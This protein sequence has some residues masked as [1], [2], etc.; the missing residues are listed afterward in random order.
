[1]TTDDV[2]TLYAYNQWANHR[3]LEAS[4]PLDSAA[5]ARNLGNSFGSLRNT[6]VHILWAEW[7]WLERWQRRSPKQVFSPETFPD[8]D[9]IERRWREIER[10]QESFVAE[11]TDEKLKERIAYENI[12]GE[13]WD[14]SLG[15]MMQHVVNHS[16]YHRGQVITSLRQLGGNPPSTDF[17]LY[18][19]KVVSI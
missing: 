10:G 13:R 18:L 5:L 11:L 6:L 14:Y 4:R 12:K 16:T 8:I 17:L 3:I 9:T 19:D 2:R 7:I 1:M 15:Q